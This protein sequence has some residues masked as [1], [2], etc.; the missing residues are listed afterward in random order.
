MDLQMPKLCGH[1]A[2]KA[3]KN[4]FPKGRIVI[5]TASV[6]QR[7]AIEKMPSQADA[8]LFKPYDELKIIRTLEQLL[9]LEFE[10]R[11]VEPVTD[12]SCLNG[13]ELTGDAVNNILLVDDQDINR[14]I[15]KRALNH[16]G[17]EAVLSKPFIQDEIDKLLMPVVKEYPSKTV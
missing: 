5:L 7:D 10:L 3:I 2:T 17:M 4:E 11:K 12:S 15:A 16:L 6:L 8:I 14:V 13:E 1:Q 9:G